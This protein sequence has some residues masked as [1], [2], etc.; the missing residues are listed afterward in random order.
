MRVFRALIVGVLAM[1]ACAAAATS[2]TA[3]TAT[4][5][6]GGAISA[7]AGGSTVLT[8]TG[9]GFTITC[10]FT[11]RGSIVTSAVVTRGV[12]VSIGSVTSGAAG[13]CSGASSLG[14]LFPTAWNIDAVFDLVGTN[15][16]KRLIIRGA[17]FLLNVVPGVAECLFRSDVTSDATIPVAG[18]PIRT[19]LSTLNFA[20]QNLPLAVDL[21]RLN[22]CPSFGSLQGSLDL[23]ADQTITLRL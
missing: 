22:V 1:A 3:A 15:V 23:I 17:Q 16:V 20:S 7:V 14:F 2:A 13:T 21:T 18:N 12:P 5:S 4:V 9:G 10:P 19:V 6:P 8:L 11:L